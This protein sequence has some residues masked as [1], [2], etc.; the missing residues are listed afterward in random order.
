MTISVLTLVGLVTGLGLDVLVAARFGLSQATDAFF[1]AYAVP[2]FIT[3]AVMSAT[4]QAVVPLFSHAAAAGGHTHR[5]K[6]A[7]ICI[8]YSLLIMPI[9]S[10]LGIALSPMVIRV[11]APTYSG[12]QLALASGLSA[13]LFVI[14]GAAGITNVARSYLNARERFAIPA[15]A[16]S[17]QNATAIVVTAFGPSYWGIGSVAAGYAIGNALQVIILLVAMLACGFHYTA[18]LDR[19]YEGL[20]EVLRLI[21][22][23]LAGSA[24]FQGGIVFQRFLAS[25]LPVGSVAA[26]GYATRLHSSF[27]VILVDNVSTALLPGLSRSAAAMDMPRLKELLRSG[28]RLVLLSTMPVSATLAV[29]AVPFVLLLFGRGQFSTSDAMLV[30]SL[31]G[32]YALGWPLNALVRVFYAPFLAWRDSFTPVIRGAIVLGVNVALMLVLLPRLGVIGIALAS[33]VA[34]I[35]GLFQSYLVLRRKL[36]KIGGDLGTYLWRLALSTVVMA[37]SAWVTNFALGNSLVGLA[38]VG[39]FLRVALPAGLGVLGFLIVGRIL[40]IEELV[41]ITRAIRKVI[42]PLP[43]LRQFSGRD[44]RPGKEGATSDE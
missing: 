31:I 34:A 24:L 30:G 44:N 16:L 41:W 8:N 4:N 37:T 28:F 42:V 20:Q 2:L 5:D 22:S 26:L 12:E 3:A 27:L 32:I 29:V 11:V 7:S 40:G 9:V 1:V 33:L 13:L 38:L 21:R 10:V 36:G 19:R 25:F 15:A 14:V 6:L 23:P 43:L 35:F 18:S 17:I 39:R